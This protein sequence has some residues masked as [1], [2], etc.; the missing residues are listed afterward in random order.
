M[1]NN[2]ESQAHDFASDMSKKVGNAASEAQNHVED[3]AQ[4]SHGAISDAAKKAENA[5]PKA[6]EG[7]HSLVEQG[8]E[9]LS[10]ASKYVQEQS[11]KL[12]HSESS[13]ASATDNNSTFGH[14]SEQAQKYASDALDSVSKAFGS[15]SDKAADGADKVAGNESY[16]DSARQTASDALGKAQDYIKK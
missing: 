8:Q 6:K 5:V 9:Y 3:A 16:L 14:I 11:Q 12:F 13:A 2:L 4:Q 15:A 10:Q 7:G 1:S